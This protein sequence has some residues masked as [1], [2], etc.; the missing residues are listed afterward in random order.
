MEAV[1]DQ[2]ERGEETE[3]LRELVE[4]LK[5]EVD[6]DELLSGEDVV[7]HVTDLAGE[8]RDFAIPFDLPLPVSMRFLKAFDR[9]DATRRGLLK[10]RKNA[11][12]QTQEARIR[13]H[14]KAWAALCFALEAIL[15]IRLPDLRDETLLE[16]FGAAVVEHFASAV[17][18]RLMF[19]RV[20]LGYGTLASP[21]APTKARPARKKAKRGRSS[22]SS[23]S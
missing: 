17:R 12:A 21:K 8:A 1:K 5:D 3:A 23:A 15:K 16:G 9:L 4:L 6:I 18:Y 2:P 14:E 11:S 22:G 10:T 20:A 7:Y 13:A 19:Q